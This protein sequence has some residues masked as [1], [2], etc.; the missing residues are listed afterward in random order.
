MYYNR[1]LYYLDNNKMMITKIVEFVKKEQSNI[2]LSVT[3]VLITITSFN[4]G[5][6]SGLQHVKTPISITDMPI[7]QHDLLADGSEHVT[8]PHPTDGQVIASKLSKSKYFYYTWCR[9]ASR[10]G[11][12]NKVTFPN[13]AAAIAAGFSVSPTCQ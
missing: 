10:I 8:R 6:L 1:T 9:G 13:T 3:V 4:L 7:P 2:V 12:K 5:R 11:S